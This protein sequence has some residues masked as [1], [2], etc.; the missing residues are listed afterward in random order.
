MPVQLASQRVV[1]GV[2]PLVP[3]GGPLLD[4]SEAAAY[5]H[6]SERWMRRALSERKLPTV[7]V[8]RSVLV[9]RAD[10]DALIESGYR[11][12]NGTAKPGIRL[13]E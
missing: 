2:P 1:V 3:P 10:L 8:G 12:A 9:R 13:G 11:P 4:Q 6:K 5:L 7:K